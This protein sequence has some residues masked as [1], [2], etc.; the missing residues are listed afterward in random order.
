[1]LK[2][3]FKKLQV[4]LENSLTTARN[5]LKDRNRKGQKLKRGDLVI[6]MNSGGQIAILLNP[7]SKRDLYRH[8]D[9]IV[10]SLL[11]D[12]WEIWWPEHNPQ[13]TVMETWNMELYELS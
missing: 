11:E 13:Y 1:M 10:T 8:G 6:V 3:T 12:G 5:F 4:A 9:H 7:W 2:E